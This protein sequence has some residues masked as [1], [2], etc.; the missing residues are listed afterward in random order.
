M[1]WIRRFPFPVR[2]ENVDD[3]LL[4]PLRL[5]DPN[6]RYCFPSPLQQVAEKLLSPP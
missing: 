3:L 2:V 1:R 5:I 6:R 4:P